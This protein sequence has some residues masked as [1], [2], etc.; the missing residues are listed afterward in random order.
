MEPITYT[1]IVRLDSIDAEGILN[2]SEVAI[3]SKMDGTNG[4][5]WMEDGVLR[6]GSRNRTL[7]AEKDN[8]GFFN[9]VNS[10]C[11][12][13]QKIKKFLN[14]F[15]QFEIF[16]EWMGCDKFIGHIKYY[17]D[18]V[19]GKF[20]IFDVYNMEAQEYV[21]EDEW[22]DMLNDYMLAPYFVHLFGVYDNPTVEQVVEIAK[23]NHSNIPE[24][25]DKIG[26]GV[27]IKAKGFTNRFG[28]H[29]YAK[30]VNSDFLESKSASQKLDANANVEEQIVQSFLTDEELNKAIA[31]TCAWLKIDEF[32]KKNSKAI[33]F[34]I[35]T[36]YRE[37]LLDEMPTIVPKFKSPII[38]FKLL[39]RLSSLRCRKF[40]GL[41]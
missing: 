19:K 7:S 8:A 35:T 34:F 27:V 28:H 5:I 17:D 22:R 13:M 33:G 40:L 25:Q 20:F 41:G 26:E 30:F 3:T 29:A 10:D 15:P 11:D 21:F 39:S 18:D 1:H 23:N 38:N 9:F 14:D 2:N 32:D 12:E 16:G 37:S 24:F 6:C 31:K 36:V 4:R